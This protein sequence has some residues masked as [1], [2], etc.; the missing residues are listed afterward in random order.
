MLLLREVAT[1]VQRLVAYIVR[2][3]VDCSSGNDGDDRSIIDQFAHDVNVPG[4]FI[5]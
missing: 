3:M 1:L 2:E 4:A 5:P